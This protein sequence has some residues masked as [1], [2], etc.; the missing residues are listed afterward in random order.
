M[1]EVAICFI[2]C[3]I[4]VMLVC[5]VTERYVSGDSVFILYDGI[6]LLFFIRRC[7]ETDKLIL[8]DGV[9]VTHVFRVGIWS[10][11]FILYQ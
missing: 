4:T 8:T 10:R 1:I 11:T 9:S 6:I 7:S 5:S 3:D 2:R